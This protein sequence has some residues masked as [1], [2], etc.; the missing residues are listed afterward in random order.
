MIQLF[1]E[2]S[3]KENYIIKKQKTKQNKYMYQLQITVCQCRGSK[4]MTFLDF[5]YFCGGMWDKQEK[6][7]LSICKKNQTQ[8]R[9]DM[10]LDL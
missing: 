2:P 4:F 5:S 1:I 9:V 8:K 6:R 10:H 7:L 3:K